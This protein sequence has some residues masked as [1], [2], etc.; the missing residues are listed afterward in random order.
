[1]EIQPAF[2]HEAITYTS[3]EDLMQRV[4]RF[5]APAMAAGEPVLIAFESEKLPGLEAAFGDDAVYAAMDVVGRNPGRLISLW[6]DFLER[7]GGSGRTVWGVGEPLYPG[8]DPEET[9][10][11]QIHEDLLNLAFATPSSNL[12]LACPYWSSLTG[13]LLLGAEASHPWLDEVESGHFRG[14]GPDLLA[15]ELAPPA[16]SDVMS[17]E[18]ISDLVALR[19]V[20]AAKANAIEVDP[21]RVPDIVLAVS[22][23]AANSVVY[24]GGGTL[25]LWNSANR[26]FCEIHDN[27]VID[28]P[29]VGRL[30][31]GRDD[32]RGRGIWLAH[33][34][35]DLLQLRSGP[36][37]TTV[38]LVFAL[39]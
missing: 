27:G 14:H 4:Q 15:G 12:K 19:R 20:V 35:A 22:E 5:L 8:R 9:V 26:L 21:D 33:Q 34:V 39:D 32:E 3:S 10:E 7:H 31:P 24:S 2:R 18:L 16:D 23:I 11:C 36:Q 6:Q 17:F 38:R 29:L 25:R 30:R 13:D 1:M 37:G 28:D